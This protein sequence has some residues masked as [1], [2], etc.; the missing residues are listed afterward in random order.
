MTTSVQ[1]PPNRRKPKNRRNKVVI[2]YDEKKRTEYL[3]GFSKRKNERKKR[4]KEEEIKQLKEE[5]R[6]IKLKKKAEYT[7]HLAALRVA[8]TDAERGG[9]R[10][11]GLPGRRLSWKRRERAA[12]RIR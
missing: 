7:S 3:T 1:P 2:E 11:R 5:K 9:G 8:M 12:H 4:A 6:N 10:T